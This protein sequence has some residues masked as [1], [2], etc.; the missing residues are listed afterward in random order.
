MVFAGI[1]KDQD[2]IIWIVQV[3][4]KFHDKC[5]YQKHTEEPHKERTV[6]GHVKTEAELRVIWP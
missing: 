5:P 4:P 1:I 6:C 2:K 3:G